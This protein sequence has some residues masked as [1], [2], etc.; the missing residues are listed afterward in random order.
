MRRL[1][2]ISSLLASA[3][4]N[5]A[6]PAAQYLALGDSYTSGESV[7][8]NDRWPVQLAHRLKENGID[9]GELTS[10]NFSP[11]LGCGI[12]MAFVAAGT[13]DGE[14]VEVEARGRRLTCRVVHLPFVKKPGR[15]A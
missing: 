11:V 4:C 15:G 2:L 1:L 5:P 12:G 9:L 14:V 13:L 10:G 6:K 7:S 8:A 3:G